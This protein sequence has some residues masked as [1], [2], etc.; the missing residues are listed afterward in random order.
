MSI[1]N[2]IYVTF[3]CR[4]YIREVDFSQLYI[5]FIEYNQDM[6]GG[7]YVSIDVRAIRYNNLTEEDQVRYYNPFFKS[8]NIVA[9]GVAYVKTASTEATEF[10]KEFNVKTYRLTYPNTHIVEYP[11]CNQYRMLLSKYMIIVDKNG[12]DMCEGYGVYVQTMIRNISALRSRCKSKLRKL[13]IKRYIQLLQLLGVSNDV[14]GLVFEFV[15][16]ATLRC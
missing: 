16:I 1:V 14:A 2:E 9:R 8:C 12:Y 5:D 13:W 11:R 10:D 6:Y 7:K 4:A 15:G 3:P